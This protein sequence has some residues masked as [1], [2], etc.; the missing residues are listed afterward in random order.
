MKAKSFVCILL[1]FLTSQVVYSQLYYQDSLNGSNKIV[2]ENKIVIIWNDFNCIPCLKKIQDEL[3][4]SDTSHFV[5]LK[6]IAN[7]HDTSWSLHCKDLYF[8][9]DIKMF[10]SYH[11][12]IKDSINIICNSNASP[13]VFLPQFDQFQS[14]YT[15]FYYPDIFIGSNLRRDFKRKVRRII[16]QLQ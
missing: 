9:K 15:I 7:D 10:F 4:K 1:N 14:L 5:V 12:R 6:I 16:R 13:L 2:P 8:N 11:E 3:I